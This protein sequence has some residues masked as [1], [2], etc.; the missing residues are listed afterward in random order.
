[1][2][3]KTI[4]HMHEPASATDLKLS[5]CPKTREGYSANAR[6]VLR[7]SCPMKG[8]YRALFQI[9]F[10]S[11]LALSARAQIYTY[12]FTDVVSGTSSSSAGGTASNLTFS[13]VTASGVGATANAGGVFSFVT[14]TTGATTGQNTFSGALDTTDYYQF[15]ITPAANFS[16]SL[17]TLVFDAGRS[18]T[19]PRQFLVRSSADNYSSNLAASV[20]NANVS[21]VAT[22]VFQIIDNTNTTAYA[23]NTITMTG[24]SSYTSVTGPLTFRIYAYNSEATTGSFRIDNLAINGSVSAIPEPSTY[25]AIFGTLALVGTVWHRRRQRKAA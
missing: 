5:R 24:L 23:G 16:Y 7:A 9:V 19:G 6:V 8:L 22:N 12:P 17:T 25:A 18:S 14:W 3:W 15:T 11:G 20:T 10:L 4:R 13:S 1:M 2:I 21:V